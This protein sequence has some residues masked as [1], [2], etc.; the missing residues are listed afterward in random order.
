MRFG[1]GYL[2]TGG[3]Y[4]RYASHG[5]A[6]ELKFH[7]KDIDDAGI[8]AGGTI[9]EDAIGDIPQN[10]TESGRIGRKCTIRSIN[11][12]YNITLPLT[13]NADNASDTVRVMLYLDKQCN[14]AT[15]VKTEIVEH[16]D[17]QSFNNLA[18][19]SRFRTLHDKTY[20]LHVGGAAP[21]G[22]A[23]VF[24]EDVV[25]DVYFGK[26]TIPLEFE[27]VT[28]AITELRSNNLGVLLLSEHGLC[29]FNS[30]C[31]LRFSDD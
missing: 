19:K 7:D 2:R 3:F 20:N 13:T 30:K 22:A 11:W 14:G 6:G 23:L 25:S 18:N 1:R 5:G 15:A 28:G 9:V 16:D 12:R 10:V 17:F 21:S 27:G 24:G 26:V 29:I 8:A 4:G 31:R